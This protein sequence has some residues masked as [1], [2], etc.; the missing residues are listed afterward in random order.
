MKIKK[1][2]LF[3]VDD[4]SLFLKLL[5]T[6]FKQS[7]DFEIETFATGE[8]CL[9]SL[10]DK[11]DFIILDYHLN[12]VNDNTLDGIDTLKKIKLLNPDIPVVILSSQD[13]IDVAVKCMQHGAFDYVVKSETAFLRLQKITVDIFQFKELEQKVAERTTQL[14]IINKDISDYRFALDVSSIVAVTDHKGVIQHVNENFCKISKYTKDELIGQ[15]HRL[16]NSGYHSKEFIHN[17]WV[18]IANGD[19]WK[20]EL[21]NKAKDGTFY[22][23]DTTIVPIVNEQGDRF[24]YMAIRTDITQRKRSFEELKTSEEYLR[25]LSENTLVPVFTLNIKT[26][27]PITINEIGVMQF[28]YRSK[29]DFLE[30]FDVSNHY[31][32]TQKKDKY[33]KTLNEKGE[34]KNQVLELKKLDGTYFWANVFMKLNSDKTIAQ[35][36]IIDVTQQMNY[37]VELETKVKERTLVLSKLLEREKELNEMKSRFV[38]NASHEFRTPLSSILT[39]TYLVEKYTKTEQQENRETHLKRISA[40]VKDLTNILTDFLSLAEFDKG[41][42]EVEKTIFNLPNFIE[43]TIMEM[44]GI[45]K[46]K[47]QH[48]KYNHIGEV[49]IEQS[50]KIL[51]NILLNLFS[52]ASKYSSEE[53]EIHITSKVADNCVVIIINDKGIGIPKEDQKNLFT[54]FFR[55]GNVENIQGTGLGLSIVK[56]YVELLGGNISFKSKLNEGTKFTINFDQIKV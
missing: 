22:W 48:I 9:E 47:H 27:K 31:P 16:V 56:K 49:T 30:N 14:E 20:G 12:S 46:E 32:N 26:L 34:L 39:S 35:A 23:V 25:N 40:S 7:A 6:E 1:I 28:G 43:S 54:E 15:D 24:K 33:L 29:K 50:K 52:N 51:K 42:V 41:I 45:L 44:E 38:T 2:K 55:A 8:L 18:T 5:E 19:I 11:P 17:L 4:D 10:S 37:H 13:K 53:K 3:L 36:V 21:K